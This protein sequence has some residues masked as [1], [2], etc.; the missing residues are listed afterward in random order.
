MF[1][2]VN[3]GEYNR[4]KLRRAK[5]G[6]VTRNVPNPTDDD[7]VKAINYGAMRTFGEHGLNWFE[8][9]ASSS[10]FTVANIRWR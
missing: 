10:P 7:G 2:G 5:D 9:E 3:D 1:G 4:H 8:D 6:T